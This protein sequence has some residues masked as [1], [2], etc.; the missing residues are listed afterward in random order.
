LLR[1]QEV[2]ATL[3][4]LRETAASVRYHAI[5]VRDAAAVGAL[6][7]DVYGR[8]GRL[9]GVIHGAGILEDRLVRDKTP[10]SF[11]R[12]Y[13]TKVDGARALMAGLRDDVRFFVQFGSISGVFGNRGQADYS[14]ANDALDSM[15]HAWAA[16][17]PG[18]VVT[19]DWGPWAGG[20]MISPEL[21]REYARRG[22]TLIDPDEGASCLLAELATATGPAQVIY[23]C[24][25]VPGD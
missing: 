8:H 6:I 12:V 20:G 1:E 23:M 16:R 21:E 13:S 2:R 25:E 19:V 24:D 3:D 15:A 17:L 10:G 11:A 4:R 7:G 22:V 5:D 18:R 14:A 9:D